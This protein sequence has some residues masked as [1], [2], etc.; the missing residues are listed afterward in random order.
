MLGTILLRATNEQSTR[1]DKLF[2]L[3]PCVNICF[4]GSLEINA[5]VVGCAAALW[6]FVGAIGFKFFCFFPLRDLLLRSHEVVRST[7]ELWA[8]EAF[9][10][11]EARILKWNACDFHSLT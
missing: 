4:A 5:H 10:A 3:L 9:A 7:R 1:Q 2:C 11:L 6:T 8:L